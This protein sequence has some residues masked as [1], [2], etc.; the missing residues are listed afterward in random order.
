MTDLQDTINTGIGV[1]LTL[2][3]ASIALNGMRNLSRPRRR[4]YPRRRVVRRRK[5]RRR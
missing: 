4:Y 1:G 5:A 3:V 2:G